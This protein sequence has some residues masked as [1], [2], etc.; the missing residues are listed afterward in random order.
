LS[1]ICIR[2]TTEGIDFTHQFIV[3]AA[4]I[5]VTDVK[6]LRGTSTNKKT[7]LA[8]PVVGEV[9]DSNVE[10]DSI[11]AKGVLFVTSVGK[12]IELLMATFVKSSRSTSDVK[13]DYA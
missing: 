13:E 4:R 10:V 11:F 7:K 3:R 8:D 2:C 5:F 12:P 1:I 6:A 9:V